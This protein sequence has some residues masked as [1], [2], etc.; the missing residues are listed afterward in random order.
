[1][2]QFNVRHGD[3][4]NE[5]QKEWNSQ[6][7]ADNFKSRTYPSK[8]NPVISAIIGKLYNHAIDNGD[9]KVPTSEFPVEFNSESVPYPYTTP[10][11]SIYDDKIDHLL[12]FFNSEHDEDHLDADIRML[13]S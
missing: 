9:V 2:N 1:M 13:R 12:E 6:L 11:K 10:I 4:P 5:P 7:P 8:T 3:E